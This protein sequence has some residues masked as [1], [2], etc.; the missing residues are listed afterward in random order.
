MRHAD[1]ALLSSHAEV[2]RLQVVWGTLDL[3][4]T[5]RRDGETDTAMRGVHGWA[6]RGQTHTFVVSV[7]DPVK[8]GDA[9]MGYTLYR[10]S[11]QT[12]MPD[13]PSTSGSYVLR[14]YS[15]FE[16]LHLAVRRCV[17][18]NPPWIGPDDGC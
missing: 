11:T 7:T 13:Y 17:P 18:F 4:R 12:S 9:L 8:H 3:R 16:W 5:A 14:R 15:D 6:G 10:V 1:T 2:L